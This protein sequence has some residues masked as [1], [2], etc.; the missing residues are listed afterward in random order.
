MKT[1]FTTGSQL[2]SLQNA[3]DHVASGG[4][5]HGYQE[6]TQYG[7]SNWNAEG[8]GVTDIVP[9]EGDATLDIGKGGGIARARHEFEERDEKKGYE[10]PYGPGLDVEVD[11][12]QFQERCGRNKSPSFARANRIAKHCGI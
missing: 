8:T 7:I 10:G 4:Q 1:S 9:I 11:P 5:F 6:D 2:A 3:V 12:G